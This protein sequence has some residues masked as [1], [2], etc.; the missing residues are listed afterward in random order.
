MLAINSTDKA[1][2]HGDWRRDAAGWGGANRGCRTPTGSSADDFPRPG[3]LTR[4][5]LQHRM[6]RWRSRG[7][8][9]Q[10][11]FHGAQASS[12]RALSTDATSVFAPAGGAFS[13]CLGANFI[14][15]II[16]RGHPQ[17]GGDPDRH[18]GFGRDFYRQIN[19]AASS[20]GF[21]VRASN[22][23]MNLRIR[24]LV[25]RCRCRWCPITAPRCSRSGRIG[26][27]DVHLPA[28]RRWAGI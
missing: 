4:R 2:R 23:R 28:T 14:L 8:L 22:I 10:G 27:D 9:G 11:L 20:S 17:R 16:G 6:A 13:G 7:L 26:P 21:A 25:T 3:A 15:V 1:V 18:S 24:T 19:A 12:R 5:R